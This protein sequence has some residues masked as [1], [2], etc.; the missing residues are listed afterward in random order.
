MTT[1]VEMRP[2]PGFD[3]YFAG[4][5]GFIY[6]TRVRGRSDP[7]R[8]PR[9]LRPQKSSNGYQQ[10]ALP[11]GGVWKSRL[12]HRLV[13]VAWHGPPPAG[14]E[15]SHLDGSRTNNRPGN[16]IWE[17][18]GAN[19]GRRREHGYDDRGY[20]HPNAALTEDTLYEVR[21]LL[22]EGQTM[23]KSRRRAA[24]LTQD[25]I[26][27]RFGAALETIRRVHRGERY[28]GQ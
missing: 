18:R 6:S 14:F 12:V 19:L 24:G 22:A 27:A 9:Q 10:I 28:V 16:L 25:Q 3:G 8:V 5:D 20:R 4:A 13:C 26:A 2:I 21:T 17:S 23:P 11:E 7:E 15:C 1:D